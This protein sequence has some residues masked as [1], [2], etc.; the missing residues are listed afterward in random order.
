[1]I[2]TQYINS[3][4]GAMNMTIL[5][6]GNDGTKHSSRTLLI[7]L[8]TILPTRLSG[9]CVTLLSAQFCFLMLG[10]CFLTGTGQVAGVKLRGEGMSTAETTVKKCVFIITYPLFFLMLSI[11][12][13]YPPSHP[14]VKLFLWHGSH[15]GRFDPPRPRNDPQSWIG[16]AAN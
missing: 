6:T 2:H 5:T 16:I 13:N 11:T 10:W 3:R 1:V 15:T 8:H 7:L 4:S 14:L 9:S 12:H